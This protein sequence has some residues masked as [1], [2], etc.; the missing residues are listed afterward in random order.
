MNAKKMTTEGL[1]LALRGASPQERLLHRL[2]SIA[3]VLN[4]HSASE[5]GRIFNDSPRAVAY[6][7][8]RFEQAGVRGLQEIPRPGRPTTLNPAQ[9]KT[10]QTYMNHSSATNAPALRKYIIKRFKITLTLRQCERIY[11]R[12]IE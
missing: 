2:H 1:S 5:A 9:M 8:K 10:L 3:L 7:V 4:G 11:K 12:L 6:W